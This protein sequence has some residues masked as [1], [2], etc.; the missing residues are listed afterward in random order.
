LTDVS[1]T[2]TTPY[3]QIIKSGGNQAYY[4]T[5]AAVFDPRVGVVWSPFGGGKTVVRGGSGLFSDLAPGFLASNYLQ[6]TRRRRTKSPCLMAR[7]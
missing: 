4:S 6:Q 3:N 2:A 7:P 5:D 1:G